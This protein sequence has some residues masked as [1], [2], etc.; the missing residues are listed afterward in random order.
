MEYLIVA[1]ACLLVFALLAFAVRSAQGRRELAYTAFLDSPG[2]QVRASDPSEPDSMAA[3]QRI[4]AAEDEQFISECQNS[5]LLH[6]FHQ[7][8]KRVA[9]RWIGRRR[10]QATAILRQ[11]LKTS[12]TAEDL[13]LSGE[14]SV[15]L[16]YARLRFLC[17]FLAYAVFLLGPQGFHAAATRANAT[18]LGFRNFSE[19]LK[20]QRR[21]TS[22]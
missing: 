3:I 13:M 16:R 9:L 17:A 1:T 8:R 12:R 11:H 20:G 6:L 18:F 5:N 14:L 19:L 7:E 22:T 4:F 21:T 10:V 2:E 15:L